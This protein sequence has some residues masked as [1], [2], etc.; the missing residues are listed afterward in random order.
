MAKVPR[1]GVRWKPGQVGR[2][3]LSFLSEE[4]TFPRTKQPMIIICFNSYTSLPPGLMRFRLSTMK[5]N[6]PRFILRNHILQTAIEHAE[7]RRFL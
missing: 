7:K 5:Q 2:G 3:S 6:N 4:D 1:V